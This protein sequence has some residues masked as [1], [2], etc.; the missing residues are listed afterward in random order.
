ME[1]ALGP[2]GGGGVVPAGDQGEGYLGGGDEAPAPAIEFAA[3][4]VGGVGGNETPRDHHVGDTGCC[5]ES[6]TPLE[7]G[8]EHIAGERRIVGSSALETGKN[9]CQWAG[10]GSVRTGS[11]RSER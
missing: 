8:E 7:V 11:C 1:G 3:A 4:G 5:G 6:K 10:G 2:I 9:E